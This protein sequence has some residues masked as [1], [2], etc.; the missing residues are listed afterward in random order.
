[1]MIKKRRSSSRSEADVAEGFAEGT[2]KA[3]YKR[4]GFRSKMRREL[5]SAS[6][7][8]ISII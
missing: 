4:R 2:A 5:I 8:R 1:M 7:S 3:E 6:T